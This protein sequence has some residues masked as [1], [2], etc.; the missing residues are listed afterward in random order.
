MTRTMNFE[1]IIMS[2]ILRKIVIL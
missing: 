1:L 2:N